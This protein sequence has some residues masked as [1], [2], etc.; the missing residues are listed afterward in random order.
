VFLDMGVPTWV[1]KSFTCD[2]PPSKAA[3]GQSVRRKRRGIIDDARA[4][5]VIRLV[6]DCVGPLEVEFSGKERTLHLT[7]LNP[8]G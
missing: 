4:S 2:A 8:V 1:A 3:P 6:D 7:A 5:E